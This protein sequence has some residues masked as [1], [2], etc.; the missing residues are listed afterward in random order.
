MEV[1]VDDDG[2]VGGDQCLGADILLSKVVCC[3]YDFCRWIRAT[4]FPDGDIL[5]WSPLLEIPLGD[6]ADDVGQ[7]SLNDGGND[8]GSL[9]GSKG[10]TDESVTH[11]G[12]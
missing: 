10:C 8:R 12:K 3:R 6:V 5:L 2:I 7:A 11:V 9:E 4:T 1:S